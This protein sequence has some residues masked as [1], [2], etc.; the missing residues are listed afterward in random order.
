MAIEKPIVAS[1]ADVGDGVRRRAVPQGQSVPIT[2][3]PEI[4]DKKKLAK[5]QSSFLDDWE[6]IIAPIIFTAAAIFTRLWKIGISDIVTWDE[7]HFG[8]FGSHYIKHEYYFD[9]HPPLGKMLVGLSGVL[10]GYNG[11][12]E[13]K[14]GEKYPEDVDYTF[15]RAFNA[16]FGILCIPMAYYTARELNLRRPAVWLVTLMVLCENSYTTISRFILLDSMLLFGT[17]ATVLCWA[18]FHNQRNDAFEPEW[19]F[20]LFMTGI[21]IGCVCSVKLVGLFVTSLVG[22]YTIEDLWTKFG[23]TKMPV[24]TLGAHV[25]T[26][27]VG[28]IVI[29]FLVYMLSFALHFAILD[30]TGPGD[31]QM[32]SLF[33]ANL[34]G[35][36]VGKNSPLEVAY[37]SRATIKNMGYGGGLLHSHVQTY[38]EGSTQQQVTCYHHKDAN[39]DWF[40]YPN[41]ADADYDPEAPPRFIG[42]GETIRLIHAQT[43][44]NLH[45]HE[46]AAPMTKADREVSSYGNLTIGDDKDHWTV[47]VV[48]DVAS[49]DRS[50]IRTLTTAFRLRHPV[51]GC[52]LRAGNVNL[53]QW[54]FKQIEV[55]CTKT[56]NP[57]DSYTHWNVEAH[58]N[59][60]LPPGD[61]GSYKSPFLH[62]F[63]HLNVAMMTSNNAL[64]PDPDK[65]DDLASQWWQWPILNVG[66]RMCG[67]DDGIVK[68]FLLGNP[69]V[70][71]G[72]TAGLGVFALVVA[73]YLV[74]WQRGYNDL[75]SKEIDQIHYAGLYPV[76]G[77]FLHY[78][79]F[80]VMARVTYVHHYYPALYFAILTFGFLADWFL[81]NKAQA[82][83]Y[84]VYGVL[85]ATVIGLYILFSPI[86]FG[87]T[88]PNKQ[89]SYLKWF[90]SWRISD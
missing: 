21:S 3:A 7:A 33:Q 53:P 46:I 67:W 82:F 83:Q 38:P 57:R 52:Y 17:V 56:N 63:I 75:N 41:R 20:W 78:L 18:K 13:F 62:D 29:P 69:L 36:E 54:G 30:H 60:K 4:D 68:Y 23:N 65:Q 40:F 77:W 5:K 25:V 37:G 2:A 6:S 34:K 66:L 71:W 49:R 27:V 76:A 8:K 22:L 42:D 15:M 87:M 9:V 89:Y 72:S 45:S 80:V 14:S 31:A 43:G 44:R 1:G 19:F 74:R 47:E 58:W 39:N 48:R 85:Y 79:P 73:W 11:S 51:L 64:V 59:E 35:T 81:R 84:G 61:P 12:F 55:T 10:A 32:S 86:C 90:D 24:T 88:G 28:L 16:L 50:K 70:Y 26:R